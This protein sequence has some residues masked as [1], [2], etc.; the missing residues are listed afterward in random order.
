MRLRVPDEVATRWRELR[1]GIAE[2]T[3]GLRRLDARSSLTSLPCVCVGSFCAL[4]LIAHLSTMADNWQARGADGDLGGLVSNS[5]NWPAFAA[6]D[7]QANK[8]ADDAPLACAADSVYGK[9]AR[10]GRILDVGYDG[11]VVSVHAPLCDVFIEPPPPGAKGRVYSATY[12]CAAIHALDQ[13]VTNFC[14][15]VCRLGGSAMTLP[16]TSRLVQRATVF[17]DTGDLALVCVAHPLAL[18]IMDLE[19]SRPDVVWANRHALKQAVALLEDGRP[20]E[21]V[22]ALNAAGFYWDG[23]M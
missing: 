2:P 14:T 8:E 18:H 17:L 4:R 10:D 16:A 11:Y 6:A 19:V 23:P 3:V 15:S 12:S 7:W 5:S 13:V 9:L 21:A 1:A 20:Y 22:G